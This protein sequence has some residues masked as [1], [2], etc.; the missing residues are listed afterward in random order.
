MAHGYFKDLL[1]E[2]LLIKCCVAKHLILLKTQIRYG[3]QRCL[4]TIKD[5]MKSKIMSS[6]QVTEDNY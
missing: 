4:A 5:V 1:E 2:Q 6:Q 3:Y